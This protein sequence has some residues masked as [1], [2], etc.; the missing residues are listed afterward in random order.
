[1]KILNKKASLNDFFE[2]LKVAKNRILMLDYDGTLSPFTPDRENAY[3]YPGI[4]EILDSIIESGNTR[5]IIISGRQLGVLEGLLGLKNKPEMWGCHGAE[6]Y[7]TENGYSAIQHPESTKRFLN[8]ISQWVEENQLKDRL[9]IKPFGLAFHWR[10]LENNI[11]KEIATKVEAVWKSQLKDF[12][13]EMKSFDGGLEIRNR[14]VSKSKAVS[15]ILDGYQGGCTAAY[16]GDDLTDEDAF[17][18][19]GDRGL[20]IL[21][22]LEPRETA[23]DIIMSP[24][25]E[26]YGFLTHWLNSSK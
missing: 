1:M 9:E 20:K 11:Q 15:T 26:L 10:G 12:D 6:H 4:R 19:I 17:N 25:E 16:L 13:L 5:L 3:P 2:K 8:S 7:T 23:A 14:K 18:A 24:P 21:V 22:R